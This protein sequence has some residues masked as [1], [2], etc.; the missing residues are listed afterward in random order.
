MNSCLRHGLT[1][2]VPVAAK[3]LNLCQ[4]WW[5]PTWSHV[6]HDW[7]DGK[8]GNG[9]KC[10]SLPNHL[11]QFSSNLAFCAS[12]SLPDLLFEPP[13]KRWL[14]GKSF[15]PS[16]LSHQ[17][18]CPDD[19]APSRWSRVKFER[20]GVAL[21]P[22][23]SSFSQKTHEIQC[24]KSWCCFKAKTP[25]LPMKDA[26]FNKPLPRLTICSTT[27][28]DKVVIGQDKKRHRA[29]PSTFVEKVDFSST[30]QTNQN[31]SKNSGC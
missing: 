19:T 6:F 15:P 8:D 18:W 1:L 11:C 27:P 12:G 25:L 2:R 30:K 20:W 7:K 16:F 21:G 5:K 3:T 24:Q 29:L 28:S 13:A 22:V 10:T 4:S 31:T 26:H 14:T 23:A 17:P 9:V